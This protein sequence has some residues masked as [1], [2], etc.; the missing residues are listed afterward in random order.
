MIPGIGSI[1][2]AELLIPLALIVLLFGA[3]R[4]PELGRALGSGVKEFRNGATEENDKRP[5]A[6]AGRGEDRA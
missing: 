3:K 1:G 4:L 2:G 6:N 5:I